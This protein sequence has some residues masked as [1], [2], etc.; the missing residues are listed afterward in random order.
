[1]HRFF[2]HRLTRSITWKI[3]VSRL[4]GDKKDSS[5]GH[6]TVTGSNPKGTYLF[7]RLC[8]YER[9]RRPHECV[10]TKNCKRSLKSAGEVNGINPVHPTRSHVNLIGAEISFS[11]VKL[12]FL[13]S[14]WPASVFHARPC[15]SLPDA[16]VVVG[17]R[18][19][20]LGTLIVQWQ[21]RYFPRGI[22]MFRQYSFRPTVPRSR[23][24]INAFGTTV[25]LGN[26]LRRPHRIC[27]Y[28]QRKTSGWINP[29]MNEPNEFRLKEK[30]L[31]LLRS[32]LIYFWNLSHM[33]Y[34]HFYSELDSNFLVRL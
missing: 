16:L 14:G 9:I 30:E 26:S 12:T 20:Y 33:W 6:Q 32:I 13:S 5:W 15:S 24:I 23:P 2:I 10:C 7:R 18:A 31:L 8:V 21:N 34:L 1:M 22:V 3:S 28:A 19:M 25:Y 11:L 27:F 17:H 29:L 4:G